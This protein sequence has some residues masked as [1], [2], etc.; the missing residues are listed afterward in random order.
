MG[1]HVALLPWDTALGSEGHLESPPPLGA[2]WPVFSRH[3]GTLVG[4]LWPV[5]GPRVH[6][7]LGWEP[8]DGCCLWLPS[9][10]EVCAGLR[11]PHLDLHRVLRLGFL[12]VQELNGHDHL[13]FALEEHHLGEGGG[14]TAEAA[15]TARLAQDEETVISAPRFPSLQASSFPEGPLLGAHLT[16]PV[17]GALSRWPA[18]CGAEPGGPLT[19]K[20]FSSAMHRS[21]FHW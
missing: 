20:Q 19:L 6:R 17:G 14:Q 9:A 8:Q 15:R 2:P 11:T 16:S 3:R 13:P 21:A 1:S 18:S 7:L 12:G 4:V 10:P 5:H